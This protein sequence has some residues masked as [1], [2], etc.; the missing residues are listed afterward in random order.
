MVSSSIYL[1]GRSL[2][3]PGSGWI[4]FSLSLSLPF[5]NVYVSR[6]SL[7]EEVCQLIWRTC[8][9]YYSQVPLIKLFSLQDIAAIHVL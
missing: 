9:P 8:A 2:P 1:G 6:L 5:L 3:A 4:D 7:H